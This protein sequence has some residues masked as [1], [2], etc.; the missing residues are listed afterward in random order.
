MLKMM[1]RVNDDDQKVMM[2]MMTI[3][4]TTPRARPPRA[5]PIAFPRSLSSGYLSANMPIPGHCDYEEGD[6]GGGDVEDDHNDDNNFQM[7]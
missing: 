3:P 4:I 6:D 2:M 5:S 7:T 1:V